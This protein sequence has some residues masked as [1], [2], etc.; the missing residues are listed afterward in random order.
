M[1]LHEIQLYTDYRY[2]KISFT[3]VYRR[4]TVYS[5]FGFIDIKLGKCRIEMHMLK[6]H[7]PPFWFNNSFIVGYFGFFS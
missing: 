3:N 7:K 1:K 2:L 4:K 5:A 6:D